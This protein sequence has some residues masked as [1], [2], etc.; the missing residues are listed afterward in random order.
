MK[1]FF[2]IFDVFSTMLNYVQYFPEKYV[3]QLLST[4]EFLFNMID[5]YFVYLD[6]IGGGWEFSEDFE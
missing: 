4:H 6:N 1:S 2:R 3:L 5:A